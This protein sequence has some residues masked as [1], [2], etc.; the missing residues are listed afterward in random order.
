MELTGQTLG[1]YRIL[2]RLGWGGMSVVYKGFDPALER[3]V[4]IK[5]LASHLIWD[6]EFV[7][8]F[9]REARAAARLRHPNIVT[10]H[11]VGQQGD[12]YYFVMEYLPGQSLDKIIAERGPLPLDEILAMTTQ[13]AAALDYAHEEGL[14]HRDVKPSNIVLDKSGRPV[15][16]D[17]GIVRAAEGTRLTSTGMTL[18][19]PEYMSPEQA[20]GEI[21]TTAS[22]LYALGVVVYEMLAGQSP[23]RATTPLAVL[24]RQASEPPPPLRE[25]RPEL[26][27]SLEQT[28]LWALEKDPAARPAT[29]AT[30][31]ATLQAAAAGQPPE[32]P[33]AIAAALPTQA[34]GMP[35][36]PTAL[37]EAAAEVE[38]PVEPAG[39]ETGPPMEPPMAPAPAEIPTAHMEEAPA[40]PAEEIAEAGAPGVPLEEAPP[41]AKVPAAEVPAAAAPTV[42]MEE[43][44]PPVE[45]YAAPPHEDAQAAPLTPPPPAMRPARPYTPPPHQPPPAAPAAPRKRFPPWGWAIV[46]AACVILITAIVVSVVVVQQGQERARRAT[47]TAQ[48]RRTAQ[49]RATE[50]ARL[51]A[52]A[53]AAAQRTATAAAQRT[54]TAAAQRTATAA[55]RRTATAQAYLVQTQKARRTVLII[56]DEKPWDSDAIPETLDDYGIPYDIIESADIGSVDLFNYRMVVIPSDQN[57]D[58]YASISR[59]VDSLEDYVRAG[60]KLWMST[61]NQSGH[62]EPLVP[63]GAVSQTE[64]DDINDVVQPGH[65]WMDGVA[66]PIEGNH[67]SHD[68]LTNLPAGAIVI[69]TGRETGE[70]TLV[71]YDL[72]RGHVCLTSQ[73]LEW[74]WKQDKDA[75]PILENTLIYMYD[76]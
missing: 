32:A 58:Y 12:Q 37:M 31:V 62:T 49:A 2:E 72:G 39:E 8:R 73:T 50:E 64:M 16:T 45:A 46:G 74:A 59:Y 42:Q 67:A 65:P 21:V 40:M 36:T 76:Y 55:A 7:Q 11:E 14:I 33:A 54:A 4:A 66:D 71:E 28:V 1:K 15:L 22:D 43:A 18:G 75:K 68:Y 17:F 26:P 52:T 44:L 38:A 3:H 60:G 30:W 48:A 24:M 56:Q 35:E 34:P 69:C 9:L 63:G 20:Q 27:E 10:I 23:F 51:G 57:S 25:K 19:T 70:A 41:P 6:Q 5:V 61:C 29:G 13:V 47:V 53:T